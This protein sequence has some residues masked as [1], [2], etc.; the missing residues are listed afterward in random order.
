[1][2]VV[3][4]VPRRSD[5]GGRRDHVWAWLQERWAREW[6]DFAVYEGHHNEGPFNRS[7]A[8]NR[9]AREAGSWDVA[10]LAD[11]DSFVGRD[12]IE[13]AIDKALGTG[14]M[15][16]A[17]ERYCYLGRQMSDRVMDGWTGNWWPGVEFTMTN[18]CSNMNVVTR[19]LWNAT[20]GFDEGFVGWGFEDCA[21]S[22]ACSALGGR[23]RVPGEMWH[24]W[25]QPSQE[26]DKRSPEWQANLA[27]LNLYSATEED[28]KKVRA[29]LDE[30]GIKKRPGRRP[31]VSVG[32]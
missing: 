2:R 16:I 10:I 3:V 12:Q 14:A 26:N 4:L 5:G 13:A 27:R 21:F 31:K 25:H 11:A 9:A 6:P 23:A 8:L 29:L 7:A 18:T 1:M 32:A 15:V 22:V 24:L 17:Y 30:L 28:P 20:G 19:K